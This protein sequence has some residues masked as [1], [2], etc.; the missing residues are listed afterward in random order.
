MKHGGYNYDMLKRSQL[1]RSQLMKCG[2][3][4]E[5]THETWEIC[6]EYCTNY[7]K[8]GEVRTFLIPPVTGR[9]LE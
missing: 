2:T 6:K 3:E 9:L 1:K 8:K 7:C 5:S 4:T